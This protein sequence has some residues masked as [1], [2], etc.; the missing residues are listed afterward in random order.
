MGAHQLMVIREKTSLIRTKANVLVTK[1]GPSMLLDFGLTVVGQTNDGRLATTGN[2]Q[3]TPGWMSPE[4]I[5]VEE[6]RVPRLAREVD[7]YAF[8]CMCYAVCHI[9]LHDRFTFFSYIKRQIST[10]YT[11]YEGV[12]HW[13]AVR[14]I[15]E[16]NMPSLPPAKD[17][18][19]CIG[20]PTP[21]PLFWKLIKRC[22][23]LQPKDRPHISTVLAYL[24][25]TSLGKHP[26]G[27]LCIARTICAR[28]STMKVFHCE[29]L[30]TSPSCR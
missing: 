16:G 24:G 26:P 10:G 17:A 19:E 25:Q 13:V 11:P 8:G 21:A 7:I 14:S 20:Y 5:A 9:F 28:E 29:V 22:W 12:G 6:H 27:T 3:G 23:A 1:E 15:L 2:A 30:K 18:Y 4:R